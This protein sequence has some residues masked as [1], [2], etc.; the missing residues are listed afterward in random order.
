MLIRI[1]TVLPVLA[2]IFFAGCNKSKSEQAAPGDS[3]HRQLRA[4][5]ATGTT[6]GSETENAVTAGPTRKPALPGPGGGPTPPWVTVG[7]ALSPDAK[8]ETATSGLKYID[9]TVGT[10]ASP[11]RGDTV[12]VHYTGWLTDGKKFDSSKDRGQPFSFTLGMGEVIKGW[13]EG[14]ASMKVGGR[15]KLVIP[16]DLAYGARNIGNGLIPPNSTLIF[17]VELLRVK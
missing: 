1:L 13:D 8:V 10:G 4:A 7:P 6:A 14:V 2:A 15:R 5:P 9:L 12:E 16:S 17:E 11:R 3:E